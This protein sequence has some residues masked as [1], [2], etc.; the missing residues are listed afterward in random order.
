[1][2]LEEF[3]DQPDERRKKRYILMHSIRDYGMGILWAAMGFFFVFPLKFGVQFV[4]YDAPVFKFCGVACFIY[5]AFRIYR[6]ITK[7][8]FN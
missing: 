6:G 3:E 4:K 8:Y 7:K 5:G 2:A 1:M